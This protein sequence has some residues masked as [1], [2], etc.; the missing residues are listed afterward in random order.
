MLFFIESCCCSL[1]RVIVH[2]NMLF[3]CHLVNSVGVS[4]IHSVMLLFTQSCCCSLSHVVV[5][6]VMLLLGGGRTRTRT[7]LS[8]SMRGKW[9]RGRLRDSSTNCSDWCVSRNSC[10]DK[11]AIFL[12]K[13]YI[14]LFL[15]TFSKPTFSCDFYLFV[16]WCLLKDVKLLIYLLI[17][18]FY[19]TSSSLFTYINSRQ[20]TS[21]WLV[22]HKSYEIV[23]LFQFNWSCMSS[24]TI[25][26][27]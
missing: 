12:F 27:C 4:V 15:F 9:W 25:P 1:S 24:K 7:G 17:V 2:Y 22:S 3:T 23:Y 16:L 20:K 10:R 21:Q 5:H 13:L 18:L 19:V 26:V 11:F 8:G 14:K 6:S